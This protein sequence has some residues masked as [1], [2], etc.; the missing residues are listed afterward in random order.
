M[1]TH[2]RTPWALWKGK[3]KKKILLSP[4]WESS[5]PGG[6]GQILPPWQDVFGLLSR[7]DD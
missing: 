5:S 1:A 4:Q 6:R 3:K 2:S 7:A